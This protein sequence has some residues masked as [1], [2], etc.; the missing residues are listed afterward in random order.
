MC[1]ACARCRSGIW[2]PR[3]CEHPLALCCS[4][5]NCACVLCMAHFAQWSSGCVHGM[6]V[7]RLRVD[8]SPQRLYFY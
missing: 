3:A 8:K 5:C 7:Y 6:R 2:V 1:A 4:D